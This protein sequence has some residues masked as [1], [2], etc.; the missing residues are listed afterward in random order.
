MPPRRSPGSLPYRLAV[1]LAAGVV[2]ARTALLVAGGLH[3]LQ[4]L[5]LSDPVWP[6]LAVLLGLLLAPYVSE[7]QA[8]GAKVVRLQDRTP[9]AGG[10][11]LAELAS[12]AVDGDAA[13]SSDQQAE[14]A[15]SRYVAL[16]LALTGAE[17]LYEELEEWRL[18]LYV[19]DE[20]GRLVPVLEHDDPAEAWQKGWDP[21]DGVVGRAFARRRGQV[22]RTP[23]LQEEVARLPGKPADAFAALRTAVA[24]PLLNLAGRPVGVL[25]AA[26]DTEVDD[27]ALGQVLVAVQAL[28]GGLARVL[29]DLAAWDTDSDDDAADPSGPHTRGG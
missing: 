11:E 4:S 16:Q 29:V 18:H 8:A 19:P 25:S 23:E 24:V 7:V 10:G 5:G 13:L 21:G 9:R 3:R 27:G 6:A 2:V 22:A 26:A 20:T 12:G 17:A 28:A 1:V 14:L 15:A